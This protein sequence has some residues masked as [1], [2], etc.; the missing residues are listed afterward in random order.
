MRGQM[1]SPGAKILLAAAL[2]LALSTQAGF[3]A[4]GLRQSCSGIVAH[5]DDGDGYH[6]NPDPDTKS[7]W[8]PAHIGDDEKSPLVRRVLKTC[9][10]GSHCHIEGLFRGHGDFY[11]TQISSVTLLKP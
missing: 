10:P 11:W 7:P 9:P 8:C 4:A 1:I 2:A 3:S 5:D 6:L